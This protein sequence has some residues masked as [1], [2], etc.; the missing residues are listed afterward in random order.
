MKSHITILFLALI[1]GYIGGTSSQFS[2]PEPAPVTEAKV[3]TTIDSSRPIEL[4]K[5]SDNSTLQI[6][7]I[8]QLKQKINDLESQLYEIVEVQKTLTANKDNKTKASTKNTLTFQTITAPNIDNLI[9]AGID[10]TVADEI[11]RRISQQEFRRMELKNLISRNISPDLQQQYL[12]ELRNLRE[13]KISLRSEIGDEGFDNYL[14]VS[15]QN[16]RMKVTTVMA[17]SPAEI[18][19]V[20]KGDVILSYGDQKI[21]S[22]PD[23][24]KATLA[25]D[26]GISTNIEIMR[27][28]QRIN[29]TVPRG[30]LGVHLTAIRIDPVQ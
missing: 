24:R 29:I 17:G 13:S 21:L 19:G 26:V 28:G 30:T 6:A 15:G 23:L 12:D 8:E 25:G 2:Q 16:N 27:D 9:S 18:N 5:D 3:I 22:W 10:P 1:A 11:L 4:Q 20:K 7:Q 14:I